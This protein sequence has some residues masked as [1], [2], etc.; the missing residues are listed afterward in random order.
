MENAL[1]EDQTV[2]QEK[3]SLDPFV[4]DE[5]EV[6]VRSIL[7]MIK[8]KKGPRSALL[9]GWAGTGKTYSMARIVSGLPAYLAIGAC[10]PTHA[11]V[12]QLRQ[13]FLELAPNRA[14]TVRTAASM[15]GLRMRNVAQGHSVLVPG[16]RSRKRRYFRDYDIM[17]VDECGML[18]DFYLQAIQAEMRANPRL[19]VIYAGDPG[20]LLPVTD[21][22]ARQ[23]SALLLPDVPP[24]FNACAHQFILSKNR[25][26]DPE[27]IPLITLA[28]TFRAHIEN[29]EKGIAT[30]SSAL[31][32]L[33]DASDRQNTSLLF[34]KSREVL[35]EQFVRALKKGGG[36]PDFA[37]VLA[38]RNDTVYALNKAIHARMADFY[39]PGE[40][41][42]PF[43]PGEYATA[44]ESFPAWTQR[45]LARAM[46]GHK[47]Y[48]IETLSSDVVESAESDD[49]NPQG[50][51]SENDVVMIENNANLRIKTVD[52]VEH[53]IFK[54]SG[55]LIGFE[56]IK[57]D[58]YGDDG[59]EKSSTTSLFHAFVANDHMEYK[60]AVATAFEASRVARLAE[61]TAA[62]AKRQAQGRPT[63]LIEME[64]SENS[65]QLS[66]YAWML[67]RA[68]A[69]IWHLYAQTFHKAQG[70][71]LDNV[72]IDWGDARAML[73]GGHT[74]TD[75]HRAL[76][77]GVTRASKRCLLY[78]P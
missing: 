67:S 55:W 23:E 20:Q 42:Q 10:A 12:S 59:H 70:S 29:P 25:R 74:I 31:P 17:L 30:L 13:K 8:N 33:K 64:D 56:K 52:S 24:V 18:D 16:P 22:S 48:W 15:L 21:R 4:A 61:Q 36:R 34:I 41:G 14:V 63:G 50:G 37:R 2:L 68:C 53:P 5:Q 27:A 9:G 7:S 38:Y 26:T 11:A 72:F 19:F 71:T 40:M 47:A 49:S 58:E 60:R 77:V 3:S 28:Q 44:N 75:Y 78:H 54:N 1:S 35:I 45:G 66:L 73:R 76:Y 57:H 62:T 65:H 32:H 51:M 69:P 39:A 46:E 43:F 6:A